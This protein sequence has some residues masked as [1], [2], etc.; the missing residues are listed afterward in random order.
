MG[1]V[2]MSAMATYGIYVYW[3]WR[4]GYFLSLAKLALFA[5]TFGVMY[6][7]YTPNPWIRHA[8]PG[9]TFKVGF[10]AVG[11]V[12]MTQY[13]AIVWRYNRGLA[14][15][16]DRSR[17]GVFR[18]LHARGGWLLGAGYVLLCLL[19]GGLL[20]T[21]HDNRWLMTLLLAVGFTSTLTHYY[22][23]GFI[24]KMRHQQNRESLAIAEP[25][26][27]TWSS[28]G[29]SW[30]GAA[31]VPPVSAVLLRQLLYF[32][33]PMVILTLGAASVWS[34]RAA[35]YIEHMYRAQSL[36]AHGL[37]NDAGKEGRLALAAMEQQLPIARRLAELQPT[38]AHEAELAFLVYNDARYRH[39][40][41]PALDGREVGP[42]ERGA[43]RAAVEEA[44]RILE[45]AS[46]G[47][48]RLG[49]F[50]REAM[51]AADATHT[52]ESWRRTVVQLQGSQG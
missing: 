31:R 45:R 6:L 12:H 24:W 2:A 16:P 30:W 28:R 36:Q 35:S 22:F 49:H 7:A 14:A 18:S 34:H 46:I 42:E 20:T 48:G 39:L 37:D 44:I 1:L 17:A 5:V 19:Y 8:A 4:K 40:V 3:C 25:A 47:G 43:H 33:V 32:G 50:G 52:L 9:W 23:D 21:R 15:R 38:S 41:I 27:Q 26:A 11:I 13:L 10:A 51:T 29:V